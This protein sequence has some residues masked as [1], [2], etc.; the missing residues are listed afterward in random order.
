MITGW[1]W[2]GPAGEM[3]ERIAY[4]PLRV[5]VA[6]FLVMAVAA[7]AALVSSVLTRRAR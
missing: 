1:A 7:V 5:A 3:A 2:T 6:L 4:T